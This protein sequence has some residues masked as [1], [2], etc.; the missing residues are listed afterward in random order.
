MCGE[1]IGRQVAAQ[2]FRG[3]PPRVRGEGLC[4]LCRE[5]LRGITPAC[6]GRSGEL[7]PVATGE[8]DHPR[9]C[10]EKTNISNY[11]PPSTGSPPRVRG[12]GVRKALCRD[13]F[14]DHP[15]V[16]GEKLTHAVRP[17][18]LVGSPPRVRGEGV[19]YTY[20][21]VADRITP[22]CAGRSRLFL[23]KLRAKR[24]HPRVCGEKNF[25]ADPPLSGIGSPPRVR[26]E[27][28]LVPGKE[29]FHGITPACA[30]RR[31]R[32]SGRGAEVED[33]PRVCGEKQRWT[34]P[35]LRKLGSPPRVRGEVC[36]RDP[37]IFVS[38]IT[39]ACAGR[40]LKRSPI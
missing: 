36:I 38:G 40:R 29:N 37:S 18:I 19:V 17:A 3:S 21:R 13:F 20:A 39:P 22:A 4:V 30:G 32:R 23:A 12:E 35:E 26:G 24:D 16:C 28:L 9:V 2:S 14:M 34:L 27:A 10:G 33:H 7:C 15:R 6:A 8:R 25:C 1:K 31:I 5:R 11:L